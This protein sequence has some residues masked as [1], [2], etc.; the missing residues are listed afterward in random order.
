[1]ARRRK[2]KTNAQPKGKY[3]GNSDPKGG[4]RPAEG[5][6][7]Q[8]ETPKEPSSKDNA[9]VASEGTMPSNA[10]AVDPANDPAW[11]LRFP[12]LAFGAGNLPWSESFG[13]PMRFGTTSVLKISDSY[14]VEGI[15]STEKT[16]AVPGIATLFVKPSYGNNRDRNNVMNIAAQQ[17][18]TNVRYVNAGRKNYEPADLM[19]YNITIA[20]LMS[21]VG[22]CQ[23]AYALGF[24]YSQRN[25]YVG[26]A[27]LEAQHINA[28]DLCAHLANFR[29]WLNAFITKISGWAMP[30]DINI[31]RRRIYMYSNI[32]TESTT[33]NLKDQM[34][35]Y[36]PDGFFQFQLEEGTS[37]G[38][39]IYRKLHD[40]AGDTGE[41]DPDSVYTLTIDQII[42]IGDELISTIYGDEDFALM[43]GDIVKAYGTQVLSLNP[44]P[45][46]M[47][48]LP[49]FE[50]YTLS[51]MKNASIVDV[52]RGRTSH[53]YSPSSSRKFGNIYQTGGDLI[54]TEGKKY[55]D[56]VDP[57]NDFA[58]L[59]SGIITVTNP[60]PGVDDT[61]EATRLKVVRDLDITN[62]I[63]PNG[64][65]GEV[66]V[67]CGSDIVVAVRITQYSW[68]IPPQGSTAVWYDHHKQFADNAVSVPAEP[69]AA[70][71][72][73]AWDELSEESE[74]MNSFHWLPLR[75]L[76]VYTG[77]V[78]GEHR[79]IIKAAPLCNIDNYTTVTER[80]IKQLHEVCLLSLTSV[81]GVVNLIN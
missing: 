34:Y 22:W 26:K 27:M 8:N 74:W 11:Y 18:F 37:S 6:S 69:T 64:D 77:G 76:T 71:K 43:S 73:T 24:M 50:E 20:E 44:I 52:D 35:Q 17:F 67:S 23:R 32:Y 62:K 78:D 51:Q 61:I 13:T 33:G 81:P 70:Q 29:Y 75:W 38:C 49:I 66:A 80:N 59:N 19:I 60:M 45:E 48:V 16:N 15:R 21:F 31:F 25:L 14:D 36:A 7:T 4:P 54:S 42:K 63:N 57:L 40:L 65:N 41:P 46:A 47:M 56:D 1:M 3:V 55:D 72:A 12:E 5:K 53:A 2:N 68:R 10:R 30:G 58:L 9:N 28:S 39:V 79:R